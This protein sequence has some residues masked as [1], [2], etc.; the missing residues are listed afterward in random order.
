[1]TAPR[2]PIGIG[3]I[4]AVV[5]VCSFA[6]H[7]S[8]GTPVRSP[9]NGT[10]S[11]F[12]GEL[13]CRAGEDGWV[14]WDYGDPRGTIED[15]IA[16]VSENAVDLDPDL[17]LSFVDEIRGPSDVFL[18]AVLATDKNGVV[19]A[20]VEFGQDEDGRYFPDQAFVCASSGIQ[21]FT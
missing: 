12:D 10:P 9:N 8:C 19:R 11:P 14:G 2:A 17:V 7:T 1:M 18:N 13:R 16:W 5:A 6:F 15:P 4:V 3:S 21:E 20:F